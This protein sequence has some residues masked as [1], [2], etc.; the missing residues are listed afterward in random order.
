MKDD[1]KYDEKKYPRA[2]KVAKMADAAVEDMLDFPKSTV[3]G[4]G[5]YGVAAAN[6]IPAAVV[7]EAEGFHNR[8]DN[9]LKEL[10]T[11]VEKKAKGGMIKSSA[12]KR[13]DGIAVKGKTRGRMV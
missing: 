2:S 5:R 4:M 12:S 13:A 9:R 3:R 1:K 10:N 7:D 8:L 11:K 6:Y